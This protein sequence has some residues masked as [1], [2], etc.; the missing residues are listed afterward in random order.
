MRKDIE[1]PEVKDVYVI[2]IKEWNDDFM[3]NCWYAYLLNNTEQ[4]IEMAMVVSSAH[5]IINNQEKKT[6]TFRHAF[7]T[8]APQTAAKVELLENNI[9]QLQNEFAVTYFLENKLFEK[10]YILEPNFVSDKNQQMIP[11]IEK[12]GIMAK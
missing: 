3:E 5:G 7:K 1:I 2:A 8:I 10:T 11:G 9:L 4:P 6:A 12:M